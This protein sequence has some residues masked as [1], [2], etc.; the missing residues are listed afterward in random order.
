MPCISGPTTYLFG[1]DSDGSLSI[2][3]VHEFGGHPGRTWQPLLPTGEGSDEWLNAR[4]LTFGYSEAPKRP[5]KRKELLNHAEGLLWEL[6]QQ[7]KT[8]DTRVRPI[9]FI[10]RG[11]GGIVIKKVKWDAE[12][13]A[14]HTKVA[15]LELTTLPRPSST[16]DSTRSTGTFLHVLSES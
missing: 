9:M 4:V 3:L 2:V 12:P 14:V 1:K 13:Q 15:N 7:R 11:T 16:P 8:E 10:G 5:Y 6:Y